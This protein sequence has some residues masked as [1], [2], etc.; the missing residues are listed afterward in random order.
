MQQPWAVTDNGEVVMVEPEV[1]LFEPGAW[2]DVEAALGTRLPSDY[3]TLIADGLACVLDEELWITSPFDPNPNLNLVR[4]L[5]RTSHSLAYL[6]HHDP[7]EFP[8]A[9]FPE[10]GGLLGWG[11]DGGGGLYAWETSDP[12]P[13]RWRVA[14]TGRAVFDPSVQ[15]QEEGLA[16]YLEG[17]A[18][19][20]IPAAAL[21]GWPRPGASVERR[22]P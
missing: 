3:K 10:P 15:V 22:K 13:D 14:V 19:G 2:D 4:E 17:L 16:G 1:W 20:R 6:R 9:P 12:D 18:S 8:D 11:S 5:A 21:G 7:V